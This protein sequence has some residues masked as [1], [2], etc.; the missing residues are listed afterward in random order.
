MLLDELY[1]VAEEKGF[2]VSIYDDNS[3][4]DVVN[5]ETGD[6]CFMPVDEPFES[7]VCYCI[8]FMKGNV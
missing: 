5:D 7:N 8:E 6:F 2:R 1:K 3:Q 4:V